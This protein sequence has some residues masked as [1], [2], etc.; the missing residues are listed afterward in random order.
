MGKKAWTAWLQIE[1]EMNSV[2]L[3][4]FLGNQLNQGH[5]PIPKQEKKEMRRERERHTH[6]H[7]QWNSD[8]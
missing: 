5:Q 3:R 6:T 1:T 8:K 4:E 2:D 7:T